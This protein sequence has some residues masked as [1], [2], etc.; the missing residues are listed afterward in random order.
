[1]REAKWIKIAK[2]EDALRWKQLDVTLSLS[3]SLDYALRASERSIGHR[4]IWT[5]ECSPLEE[6][7]KPAKWATNTGANRKQT[8][9]IIKDYLEAM[10][11]ERPLKRT[12]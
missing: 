4:T 3:L 11:H 8:C 6:I 12:L 7:I 10:A 2:A 5:T 9:N 1:M